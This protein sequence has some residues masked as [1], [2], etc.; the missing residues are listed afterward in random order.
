MI[1]QIVLVV[2]NI[3]NERCFQKRAK[4]ISGGG[5]LSDEFPVKSNK[6]NSFGKT[7]IHE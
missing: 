4:A 3:N 7:L 2:M 6:R 1:V 5:V